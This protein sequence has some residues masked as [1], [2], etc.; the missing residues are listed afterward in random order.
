MKREEVKLYS[1]FSCDNVCA[2]EWAC[3]DK[4]E[5]FQTRKENL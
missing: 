3:A 1:I 2:G 4:E 5:M